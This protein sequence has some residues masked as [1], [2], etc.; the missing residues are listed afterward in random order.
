MESSEVPIHKVSL[1]GLDVNSL[2]RLYDCFSAARTG[3]ATPA[4]RLRAD[5][6]RG[7]VAGELR[8]RGACP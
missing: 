3:A 6:S 8:R 1:R 2:L 5:R 4:Q 7:R